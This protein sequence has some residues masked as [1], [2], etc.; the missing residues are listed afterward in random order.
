MNASAETSRKDLSPTYGDSWV[1]MGCES[2]PFSV[3]DEAEK[4]CG[5]VA[6]V[7]RDAGLHRAL[8]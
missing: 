7:P 6:G 8:G 3:G 2:D 5:V 1:A 4:P